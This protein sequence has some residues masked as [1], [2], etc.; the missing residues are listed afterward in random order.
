MFE[1]QF[2][3]MPKEVSGNIPALARSDREG[4]ENMDGQ[5]ILTRFFRTYVRPWNHCIP[6][7][8]L[9][10]ENLPPFY[11]RLRDDQVGHLLNWITTERNTIPKKD[12]FQYWPWDFVNGSNVTI[13]RARDSWG[14]AYNHEGDEPGPKR[15]TGNTSHKPPRYVKL[16]LPLTYTSSGKLMVKDLSKGSHNTSSIKREVDDT[17][18]P[19]RKKLRLWEQE[20]PKLTPIESNKK[21]STTTVASDEERGFQYF[22][23]LIA[24]SSASSKR[25]NDLEAQVARERKQFQH[26]YDSLHDEW[27]VY[28]SSKAQQSSRTLEGERKSQR[29][30]RAEIYKLKA[31]LDDSRR[32]SRAK[33]KRLDFVRKYWDETMMAIARKTEE[34]D[35]FA[36]E[37]DWYAGV[38]SDDEDED[39]EEREDDDHVEDEKG[40]YDGKIEDSKADGSASMAEIEKVKTDRDV[41][42]GLVE[43]EFVKAQGNAGLESTV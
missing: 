12:L 28:T 31:E 40:R 34:L 18:A 33:G 10:M 2:T 19:P 42:N 6:T 11:V 30:L 23:N 14:P 39:D 37:A 9:T 8:K 21:E 13:M 20:P 7:D 26:I 41:I 17:T 38:Y 3:D 16:P 35:G 36:R 5:W 27:T 29:G 4:V 24:T 22:Q 32:R 1:W 25:V 15:L 43:M